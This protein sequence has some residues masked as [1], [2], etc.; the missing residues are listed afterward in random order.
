M[1]N[2]IHDRF[3]EFLAL[4]SVEPMNFK[5]PKSVD[6]EKFANPSEKPGSP[7][8]FYSGGYKIITDYR[9]LV[10][11]SSQYIQEHE[12]KAIF[13]GKIIDYRAPKWREIAFPDSKSVKP[14]YIDYIS[15]LNYISGIV[16]T[17]KILGAKKGDIEGKWLVFYLNGRCV[18]NRLISIYNF[19]LYLF[20]NNINDILCVCGDERRASYF[21]AKSYKSVSAIILNTFNLSEYE[22]DTF[23][24]LDSYFIPCKVNIGPSINIKKK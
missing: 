21:I 2:T 7:N 20:D 17:L 4:H 5:K 18:G 10:A 6:Y 19:F 13:N 3:F 22:V 15:T 24:I 8:I 11:D 23:N 9:M 1:D 14:I 16:D 12:G